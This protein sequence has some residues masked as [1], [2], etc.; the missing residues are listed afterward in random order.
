MPVCRPLSDWIFISFVLPPIWREITLPSDRIASTDIPAVDTAMK[1]LRRSAFAYGAPAPKQ[2]TIPRQARYSKQHPLAEPCRF[3]RY[4]SAPSE[5]GDRSLQKR[6][7][8]LADQRRPQSEA[9]A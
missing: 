1:P 5:Y 8:A 9:W 4:P 2:A 6:D 3:G 7:S